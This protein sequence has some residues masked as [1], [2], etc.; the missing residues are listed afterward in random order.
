MHAGDTLL[1]IGGEGSTHVLATAAMGRRLGANTIAF[2]WRHEMNP[3]ALRSAAR[4]A[5][6]CTELHTAPGPLSALLLSY[7]ARRTRA[8][9][10]IP[11]GGNSALGM[12]GH[13]NAALEL[14]EQVTRGE[15]PIPQRVVVPLGSGGTAG[16]L[17]LGFAIAGLPITVT[18]ARVVTRLVANR[19]HVLALTRSCAALITELSGSTVPNVDPSRLEVLHDVYGGAYGRR[20][21]AAHDSAA[22]LERTSGIH[23]DDTYSAKAF[24]AALPLAKR[25]TI[26]FWLTFDGGN[27]EGAEKRGETQRPQRSAEGAEESWPSLIPDP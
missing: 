26:L 16:G 10:W 11:P 6:L 21:P 2:R 20:L 3:A 1:T 23:L 12:L 8:V 25:E 27:A 17:A 15:L 14:A 22:L 24:A 18:A 7:L 4:A 19:R 9:R 13:V 5:E